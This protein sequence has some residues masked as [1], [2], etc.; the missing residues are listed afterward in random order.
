[1]LR[2]QIPSAWAAPRRDGRGA[3][4]SFLRIGGGAAKK[5]EGYVSGGIFLAESRRRKRRSMAGSFGSGPPSARRP[6]SFP[7][8]FPPLLLPFGFCHVHVKLQP[9]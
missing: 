9:E 1:M 4:K 5:R 6:L 8:L 3:Q 2:S 7:Q